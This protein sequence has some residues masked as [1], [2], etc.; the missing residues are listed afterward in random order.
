MKKI[1]DKYILSS[2]FAVNYKRMWP[3]I[4]P[5]F[6]KAVLGI[7]LTIPVGS[8][9][10][11]V[12]MLLKPFMDNVLVEKEV[13]FSSRLPFYIMGLTF[14]QGSFT[15]ASSYLNAWVG[16]KIT[17]GVKRALYDKL[18]KMD[19]SYFDQ[20]NSGFIVQRFSQ[21]AEIASN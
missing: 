13:M 21:D 12:A 7:L 4:K 20:H 3:F 19:S 8:L 14:L 6:G 11:A 10:A 2:A 1:I 9:D 18:L 5:Y 15:Y 16:S 17:L